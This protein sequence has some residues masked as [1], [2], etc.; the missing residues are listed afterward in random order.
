MGKI[1][2]YSNNYALEVMGLEK[3]QSWEKITCE[4]IEAFIGFNFLMGLNPKPSIVDY[5][6]RDP[7]S[8]IADK[9]SR[10]R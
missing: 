5:W 9:I 4:E 10:Q 8:P 1:K 3:F 6:K 2:N 7:Y